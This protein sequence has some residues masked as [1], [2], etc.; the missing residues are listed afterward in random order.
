MCVCVSGVCRAGGFG[1]GVRAR[2]GEM[3]VGAGVCVCARAQGRR[4]WS[5]VSECLPGTP[6]KLGRGGVQGA[7]L[8]TRA[9]RGR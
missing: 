4:V 6:G 5:L 7:P 2:A 8:R 3:G 1:A 9:A